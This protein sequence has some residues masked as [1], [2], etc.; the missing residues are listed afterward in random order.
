MQ[1]DAVEIG[2]AQNPGSKKANLNHLLNFKYS[3]QRDATPGHPGYNRGW[4]HTKKRT[5]NKEQFVQA[6][7]VPSWCHSLI[8]HGIAFFDLK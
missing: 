3:S 7:L 1:D 6:K 5:F 8:S 4:R 2:S